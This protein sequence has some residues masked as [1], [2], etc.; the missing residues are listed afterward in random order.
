MSAAFLVAFPGFPANLTFAG[1]NGHNRAHILAKTALPAI[2]AGAALQA[3][4]LIRWFL[5]A[6]RFP[7]N[8]TFAWKYGQNL[9]KKIAKCR[10]RFW[11]LFPGSPQTLPLQGKMAIIGLIFWRKQPCRPLRL[12]PR[13]KLVSLF[14]GSRAPFG[15]PQTLPLLGNI[16]KICAKNS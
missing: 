14:G 13:S 11:S 4:F 12:A 16:A 1:E 8:L 3:G 15:S 10:P 9:R 7:A 2:A 5:G 6:F